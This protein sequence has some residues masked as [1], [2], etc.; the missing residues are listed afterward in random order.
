MDT[1]SLAFL[2]NASRPT[3][4]PETTKTSCVLDTLFGTCSVN[5]VAPRGG[6]EVLLDELEVRLSFE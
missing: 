6:M 3:H 4:M 5:R 1:V 2:E